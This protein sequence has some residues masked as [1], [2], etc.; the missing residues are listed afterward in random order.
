MHDGV[1]RRLGIISFTFKFDDS[2]QNLMPH[3]TDL[4][5]VTLGEQE[6]A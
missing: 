1:L 2:F 4:S 5:A 6:D 3:R